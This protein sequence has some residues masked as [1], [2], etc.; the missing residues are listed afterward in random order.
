MAGGSKFVLDVDNIHLN[1]YRNSASEM[2]RLLRVYKYH[3]SLVG[4]V[5]PM[6]LLHHEAVSG[7]MS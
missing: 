3:Y 6:F 1:L 2:V 4:M 7:I 5:I